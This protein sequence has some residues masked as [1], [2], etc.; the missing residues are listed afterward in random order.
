MTKGFLFLGEVLLGQTIE[1]AVCLRL[2]D[3]LVQL[4][5]QLG[6]ALLH[7]DT[8]F[9]G[10]LEGNEDG[11]GCVG[12]RLMV[13]VDGQL[14]VKEAVGL[15]LNHFGHAGAFVRQTHDVRVGGFFVA[16]TSPVEPVFTATFFP[17]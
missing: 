12:V 6:V 4:H 3:E 7:G 2:G 14:V 13:T 16:Y 11:F 5:E 1:L 8:P 10:V 17:A 9:F 15:A